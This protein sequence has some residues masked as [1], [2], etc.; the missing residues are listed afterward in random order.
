MSSELTRRYPQPVSVSAAT[1]LH[2][3]QFRNSSSVASSLGSI[4]ESTDLLNIK[5]DL[6]SLLPISEKRIRHLQR[7]LTNLK[8]NIRARD[9]TDEEQ[10]KLAYIDSS[11]FV[12]DSSEISH[13]TS[14]HNK[15]QMERQLALEAIR[16]K[17]KRDED[18]KNSISRS[19]LPHQVVR[20]KRLDDMPPLGV[21]RSKKK[22]NE[23]HKKSN[24]V[25]NEDFIRVKAKDQIPILTFWSAMD[26]HFRP[27]SEQDRAFLLAKEDDEKLYTIPPLGRH[28]T[29]VWSLDDFEMPGLS[30]TPSLKY[31]HTITEDQLFKQDVSCGLLTE[32]LLSSLVRDY[33]NMEHDIDEEEEE[34]ESEDVVYDTHIVDFED[35]LKRELHY[36]GLFTEDDASIFYLSDVAYIIHR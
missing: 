2:Y 28:Y 14:S 18:S 11:S 6:E 16:R 35:R 26:A 30:N 25:N 33:S 1:A 17:R 5:A 13:S 29:D 8:K 32:R 12:D 27:L 3:R 21:T 10:R 4:P 24:H 22:S 20:L 15:N 7:D 36:A 23:P 19:E 9:L 31:M 34:E